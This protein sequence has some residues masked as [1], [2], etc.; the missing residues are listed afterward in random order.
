MQDR[1][2][3]DILKPWE[4]LDPWQ[5]EYIST[6]GNCFLLCGRQSG[7]S[8]AASI[9]FGQ[10]ALDNRD[11]TILMLAFTEKQAYGLFSKTLAYIYEHRANLICTGKDAPTQHIIKLKNGSK[12]L[13]YAAGKTGAGIRGFTCDSVVVDEAAMMDREIFV[14]ITPMLS[15]T[16]GSLD[17]LSTP[18]G[19]EG[20]FY[21][22]SDDE[23]LA[24]KIMPGW[25]RFYVSA[26][27]CPRHSK[28]F[29]DAE[30][31]R[32]TDLEYAQ[33]YLAQFL[34]QFRRVFSDDWIHKVC[35][36]ARQES[37]SKRERTYLG[38][39]IA[40]LGDDEGTYEI[41]ADDGSGVYKHRENLITKKMLTNE[42]EDK[43][44]EIAKMW[45]C[46]KV[47]I[48]AGAGTLG[49]SVLDH[50][51]L[52]EIKHKVVPLNNRQISL[53]DGATTQKFLQEDMYYLTRR[54]GFHGKLQLLDDTE[55][56]LSLKSIQFEHIV[57]P[58]VPT[59]TK[60]YGVYSHVAEGIIRAVYLA[61][62]EKV[63]NL[64]AFS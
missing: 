4:T 9:K 55:V 34:D 44:L 7:K 40:R 43:I 37:L 48:D 3:Y 23:S 35:V 12:I 27:D 31:A 61:E 21:E 59:K 1:I 2:K 54:L 32:M 36:L 38:C 57:R 26:E 8:T 51:K 45:N 6:K 62:K 25:T 49:V 14:A 10:R 13:C 58:G 50:L 20:Y 18:Q 15:V 39:D 60:I 33:E 42:T 30:K 47:G 56:I 53:D 52:T 64:S 28:E 29:L 22:C 24:D 41:I 11:H 63:L 17:V 46:K 19:K 16:G 5:S